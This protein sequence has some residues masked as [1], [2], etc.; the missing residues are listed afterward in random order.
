MAA[1]G[2]SGPPRALAQ[3]ASACGHPCQAVVEAELQNCT[4]IFS[5]SSVPEWCL[6]L[7]L[8]PEGPVGGL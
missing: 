8:R 1:A 4:S 2:P 6:E 5:S 3:T 7:A